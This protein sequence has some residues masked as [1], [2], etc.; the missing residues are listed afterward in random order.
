MSVHCLHDF[1][2]GVSYDNM[3]TGMA[4][5]CWCGQAFRWHTK[6]YTVSGHGPHVTLTRTVRVWLDEGWDRWCEARNAAEDK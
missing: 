5:C 4:K 1:R 6:Q 2:I 3:D